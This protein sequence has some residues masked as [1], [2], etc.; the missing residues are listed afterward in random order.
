MMYVDSQRVSHT[1]RSVINTDGYNYNNRFFIG[2]SNGDMSNKNYPDTVIDEVEIWQAKR[3]ILIGLGLI[4]E[5]GIPTGEPPVETTTPTSED[6]MLVFNGRSWI[7]YDFSELPP[8]YLVDNDY[9]KFLIQ[10]R[11][12]NPNGL[13]WFSGTKDRNMHL[14]I[15]EGWLE[16]AVDYGDGRVR[17]FRVSGPNGIRLDNG[18]WHDVRIIRNGRRVTIDV[19][20]V[21]SDRQFT[22]DSDS[23]FI[24]D[25]YVIVGGYKDAGRITGQNTKSNFDGSIRKI[26]M[27]GDNIDDINLIDLYNR[28]PRPSWVVLNGLIAE[29]EGPVFSFNGWNWITYDFSQLPPEYSADNSYEQLNLQL[30]TSNPTGLIWFSGELDNKNTHFSMKDGYLQLVVDYG[31]GRVQTYTVSG[32]NGARLN[33]NSWH[34][35]RVVRDG[36]RIK[37][38]VD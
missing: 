5:T 36:R 33:D 20:G 29:D 38:Y 12:D 32:P 19:D 18:Q 21:S 9:E 22:V 23:S 15:K 13:L 7:T 6:E 4:D 1:V 3:D 34:D 8:Q 35:I 25:G 11:T 37:I 28:I 17:K 24:T 14:N 10:F 2:R 27:Q 26:I 30:K 31:N 16:L